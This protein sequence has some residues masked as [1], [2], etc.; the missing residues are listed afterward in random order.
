MFEMYIQTLYNI[1]VRLDESLIS[2]CAHSLNVL[3]HLYLITKLK[4]H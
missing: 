3:Y 2:C 4:N 1:E